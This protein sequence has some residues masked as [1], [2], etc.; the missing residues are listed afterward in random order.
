MARKVIRVSARAHAKAPPEA[1]WRMLA[2]G[3]K[4]DQWARMSESKLERKGEDERNGI[5]AVRRFR[6]GR[7]VTR[8]EVIAFDAPRHFAYR[9]LSGMPVRDYRS[10]VELTPADGGTDITW[11]S[12][13]FPSRDRTSLVL[14]VW[15]GMVLRDYSRRLAKA[16]A[17]SRPA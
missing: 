9:L 15:I 12:V 1:V 7:I 17:K 5:G 2:D 8:E 3:A 14:R 4:W 6:T 11:T 16:A 13:F 10:D